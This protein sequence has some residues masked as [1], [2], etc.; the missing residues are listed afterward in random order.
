MMANAISI[1]MCMAP[2]KGDMDEIMHLHNIS[3]NN[4]LWSSSLLQT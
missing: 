3:I 2:K 1:E 4:V